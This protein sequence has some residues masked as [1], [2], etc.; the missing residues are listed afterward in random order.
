MQHPSSRAARRFARNVHVRKRLF[1]LR[2][3]SANPRQPLDPGFYAKWNLTCG[4]LMC[5]AEKHFSARR[6]RREALKR[7]IERNIRDWQD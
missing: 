2:H 6:R 3:S 5:H 7:D 1:K 4:A